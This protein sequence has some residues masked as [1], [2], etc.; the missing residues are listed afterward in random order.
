MHIEGDISNL[1]VSKL[2]K[3]MH[4]GENTSGGSGVIKEQRWAHHALSRTQCPNI[5]QKNADLTNLQYFSGMLN[6]MLV[7][8]TPGSLPL[9]HENKLKFTAVMANLAH[10]ASWNQI[11]EL[12]AMFFRSLEQGQQS[13]G[14]WEDISVFLDRARHQVQQSNPVQKSF[15]GGPP[16]K[17]QRGQDSDNKIEGIPASWIKEKKFCLVFNIGKCPKPSD[18][19]I[20][21]GAVH[22][23]HVC[24]GCVKL[25]KGRQTDHGAS[26]CDYRPF[27]NLF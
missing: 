20:A 3:K 24:A 6:K 17:R 18:Y 22:V 12:N 1:D 21:E 14:N 2:K 9:I 15:Q 10:T 16:N 25:G 4:S 27:N 19:T 13:W 5:P 7:E 23:T 8:V 11:L 26:S